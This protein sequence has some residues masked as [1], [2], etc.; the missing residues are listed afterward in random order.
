MSALYVTLASKGLAASKHN[1]AAAARLMGGGGGGGGMPA[2]LSGPP[3]KDGP[4]RRAMAF[5]A[6]PSVL[7]WLIPVQGKYGSLGYKLWRIRRPIVLVLASQC[8]VVK[9]LT[10]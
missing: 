7:F 8:F 10:V 2:P 4:F 6:E 3:V 5:G 1:T 9:C